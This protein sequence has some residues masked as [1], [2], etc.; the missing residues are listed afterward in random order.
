MIPIKLTKNV[1]IVLVLV[2][3]LGLIFPIADADAATYVTNTKKYKITKKDSS[4]VPQTITY[5]KD[6]LTTALNL[7]EIKGYTVTKTK[8]VPVYKTESKAF[9]KTT[10]KTGISKNNSHFSS[11]YSINESGYSGTIPRTGISWSVNSYYPTQSPT[12]TQTKTGSQNR[13]GGGCP[14]SSISVSYYDPN[15]GKTVTGNIPKSGSKSISSRT[16]EY[17]GNS[18]T[19]LFGYYSD[20]ITSYCN[21]GTDWV[22]Y[23]FN[24]SPRKTQGYYSSY[25]TYGGV[26]ASHPDNGWTVYNYGWWINKNEPGWDSNNATHGRTNSYYKNYAWTMDG[27]RRKLVWVQYQRTKYWN[28]SQAYKGTI[29]LPKTPKDYSGTATYSGTLT[30]E[31]VDHYDTVPTEWEAEAVYEGYINY[32]PTASFNTDYYGLTD[33]TY[34][35]NNTSTD[36]DGT[37]INSGWSITP[38]TGVTLTKTSNG[39]TIKYTEPGE[40]NLSLTVTDSDGATNTKTKKITIY[41]DTEKPVVFLDVIP[42]P[43][44]DDQPITY[45]QTITCSTGIEKYIYTV[46]NLDNGTEYQYV[47]KKPPTVFENAKLPPGKYEIGLMALGKTIDYGNGVVAQ[48]K[49]SDDVT[50]TIEVLPSLKINGL[51]LSE[52]VNHPNGIEIPVDYPVSEP[53]EIN[54]GYN[55]NFSLDV[56]GGDIV[57]I[58]NYINGQ[59]VDA[60]TLAGTVS[61]IV[62]NKEKSTETVN[63]I[64]SLD[65]NIP[66][67]TVVDIKIILSLEDG[68]KSIVNTELGE[69]A[70][71]IVGSAKEDSTVNLI[72]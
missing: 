14:P 50:K 7:K 33:K 31:V 63:F 58:R 19:P 65:R 12:I 44:D 54:T 2:M 56:K 22:T 5:T 32:P 49:W 46:T 4:Q 25:G 1:S 6:G 26:A 9:T 18:S 24:N 59:P 37:I 71:K 16:Y 52:A 39:A 17:Q 36:K 23:Y 13:S 41:K 45:S 53:V 47:N 21:D 61:K 30:K 64:Y 68:T 66:R 57:T 40:Y 43:V 42:S 11:T 62:I 72:K 27:S 3:F 35:V 60:V 51:T 28:W 67:D 70:L 29:A 34:T 15:S 8:Q 20:N 48:G 55:L 38:S 10:T 69:R